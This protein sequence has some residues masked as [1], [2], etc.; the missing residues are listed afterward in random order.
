QRMLAQEADYVHEARNM[1]EVREFFRPQDGVVVPKVFERY[2]TGRVLTTEYLDGPHLREFLAT[3][4]SES[5]RSAFA[6]TL[7]RGSCR[8]CFAYL[9]YGDPHPGNFKFMADGKLGLLDFGCI[10]RFSESDREQIRR[11][12][13]FSSDPSLLP[14]LLREGGFATDED[15]ADPEYMQLMG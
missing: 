12:D 14:E 4:P 11:T 9:A 1:N 8:M 13:R 7:Y 3:N 15:L 6:A 5:R 2:S 10:Q